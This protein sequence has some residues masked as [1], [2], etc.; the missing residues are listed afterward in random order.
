VRADS[1]IDHSKENPSFIAGALGGC[2]CPELGWSEVSD[3]ALR[4]L[5]RADFVSVP[6]ANFVMAGGSQGP[7]AP[8]GLIGR[9]IGSGTIASA[10]AATA[11]LAEQGYF[12]RHP[13]GSGSAWQQV[14]P[15]LNPY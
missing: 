11:W 4:P 6:I 9:I 14:H 8:L 15:A 3:P 5:S 2:G 10:M 12:R 1:G 13:M 7:R